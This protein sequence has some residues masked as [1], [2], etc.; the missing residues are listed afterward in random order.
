RASAHYLP[1]SRDLATIR[2][3]LT[4]P[5]ATYARQSAD[6][7]AL[8]ALAQRLGF[9]AWLRDLPAD[10]AGKAPETRSSD[11]DRA[12]YRAITSAEALD[13]LLLA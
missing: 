9:Q 6:L 11:I 2:C 12:A 8:R 13:A 10:D 7:V 5:V 4:L 3:G 1:L